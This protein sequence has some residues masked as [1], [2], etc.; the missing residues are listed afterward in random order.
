MHILADSDFELL[1]C[2]PGPWPCSVEAGGCALQHDVELILAQRLRIQSS[3]ANISNHHR[4]APESPPPFDT[5]CDTVAQHAAAP[6][7]I[8]KPLHARFSK[9]SLISDFYWQ[10]VCCIQRS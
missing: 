5:F 9:E 6:V 8:W 4:L 1:T 7:Q 2:Q 10:K 3:E